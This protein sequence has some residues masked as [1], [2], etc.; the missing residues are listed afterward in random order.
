MAGDQHGGAGG[1]RHG[2]NELPHLLHTRRIQT[3]GGLIQDEQLRAAQQGHGDAQPLFHAQGILSHLPVGIGGQVHDLQHPID[4]L[5]G[6][7][8]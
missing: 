3:V 8:L 5:P 2:C 1:L 6:Y 7:V 4:I